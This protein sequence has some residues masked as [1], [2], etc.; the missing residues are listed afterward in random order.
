H[1]LDQRVD[2]VQVAA[3]AAVDRGD[4]AS[5]GVL[6]V[7][8]KAAEAGGD[9]P[10]GQRP[11][12]DGDAHAP[13]DQ[14]EHDLQGAGLGRDRGLATGRPIPGVDDLADVVVGGEGDQRG[15]LEV[16]GRDLG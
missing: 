1:Q 8:A 12:Q 15:A 13:A 6:G 11:G 2:E 4:D 10:T 3:V 9:A 7:Q 5:R 16:M 14:V